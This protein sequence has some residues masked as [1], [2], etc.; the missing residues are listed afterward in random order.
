[1]IFH[2]NISSIHTITILNALWSRKGPA[3]PLRHLVRYGC[4]FFVFL[5]FILALSRRLPFCQKHRG[6]FFR[7][8]TKYDYKASPTKAVHQRIFNVF[9]NITCRF[10][11]VLFNSQNNRVF[12]TAVKLEVVRK[13]FSFMTFSI[14]ASLQNS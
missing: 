14:L 3:L 8:E 11:A 4:C 1:M 12:F 6:H 2:E 13:K 10:I 7:C 5:F 9:I